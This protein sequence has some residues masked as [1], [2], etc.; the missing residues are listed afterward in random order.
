[1]NYKSRFSVLVNH[2]TTKSCCTDKCIE[3]MMNEMSVHK[4]KEKKTSVSGEVKCFLEA[5]CKL[6][7]FL[8]FA[9]DESLLVISTLTGVR[10]AQT[11]FDE[12]LKSVGIQIN[13]ED[14]NWSKWFF[15]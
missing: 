13:Q 9:Q 1:M 8:I 7:C 11:R 3:M 4:K 10:L 15:N 14:P 5:I 6:L 2:I 12:E